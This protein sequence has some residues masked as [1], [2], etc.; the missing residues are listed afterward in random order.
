VPR[1]VAARVAAVVQQRANMLQQGTAL[2]AAHEALQTKHTRLEQRAASLEP[3]AAATMLATAD[4]VAHA[5]ATKTSKTSKRGVTTVTFQ[6][7]D[8]THDVPVTYTSALALRKRKRALQKD[9]ADEREQLLALRFKLQRTGCALRQADLEIKV[10]A[11][12]AQAALQDDGS[13][14]AK[15]TDADVLTSMLR[16]AEN[17][18][19]S[20]RDR[21]ALQQYR[22][23]VAASFMEQDAGEAAQ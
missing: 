16:R 3:A 9:Y 11:P 18:Q 2:T 13:G 20:G 10:T 22:Q 5:T 14:N 8:Q 4:T 12:E 7:D 21:D 6:V 15:A 17:G 23:S 19:L 1:G